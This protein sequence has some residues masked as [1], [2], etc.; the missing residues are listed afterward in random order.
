MGTIYILCSK[1]ERQCMKKMFYLFLIIK[2]ICKLFL[3]QQFFSS[4]SK[5]ACLFNYIL[6][7][8]IIIFIV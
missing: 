6:N 8:I 5:F 1:Q 3:F 4:K 2:K 7:F